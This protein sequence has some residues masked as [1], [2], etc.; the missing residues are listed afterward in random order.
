[1]SS[2]NAIECRVEQAFKAYLDTATFAWTYAGCASATPRVA[3]GLS[4]QVKTLPLIIVS[5]ETAEHEGTGKFTGNWIATVRVTLREN[6]DDCTE[7]EHLDH[8]GEVRDF[9]ITDTITADVN[10][11]AAGILVVQGNGIRTPAS[12]SRAIVDRSWES[13]LEFTVHCHTAT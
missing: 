7:D 1:M 12:C 8:S 13:T 5:C 9:I 2:Y 4:A 6:A 3:R 10:T 11:A